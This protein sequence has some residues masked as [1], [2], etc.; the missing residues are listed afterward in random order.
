[1]GS[2]DALATLL[3][4]CFVVLSIVNFILGKSGRTRL[5]STLEDWALRFDFQFGQLGVAEA[6]FCSRILSRCFGNRLFCWRRF[7]SS[8]II[9]LVG[10]VLCYISIE[11]EHYLNGAPFELP[12]TPYHF[13][14]GFPGQLPSI[15]VSTYTTQT[16]VR[17][18]LEFGKRHA[19]VN[20]LMFFL[21]PLAM[22]ISNLVFLTFG[23]I[24]V[25]TITNLMAT[26]LFRMGIAESYYGG[27]VNPTLAF[28]SNNVIDYYHQL[29]SFILYGSFWESLFIPL[30]STPIDNFRLIAPYVYRYEEF[31][32]AVAGII[33]P[34]IFSAFIISFLIVRPGHRLFSLVLYRLAEEEK[35][36]LAVLAA[37]LAGTIK[38]LQMA[39]KS[40]TGH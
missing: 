38:L 6:D 20:V 10:L 28:I 35:G 12:F 37:A 3:V 11:Y 13:G 14:T 2:L 26:A 16:I 19:M 15:M 31:V 33:R 34:I 40:T 30:H 4:A 32:R 1:M 24:F 8:I 5:Q 39:L 27:N 22:I 7:F 29:F 25:N 36:A 18:S 21:V 17:L 9:Y 23:A